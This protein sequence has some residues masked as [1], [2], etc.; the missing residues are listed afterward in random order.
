MERPSLTFPALKSLFLSGHPLERFSNC[1]FPDLVAL[2]GG[3]RLRSVLDRRW[4][5]LQ[6]LSVA[7][8]RDG[9]SDLKL[10]AQSDCCPNLTTLTV[11][12]YWT[13]ETDFS[14]LAD[15]PNMPHLSLV[16]FPEYSLERAYVIDEGRLIPLRGDVMLDGRKIYTPYHLSAPF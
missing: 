15:C 14:F 2:A 5:K 12:G 8:E 1:E 16:H 11:A 9:L 3:V 6:C 4:P 13:A 7:V 10:F